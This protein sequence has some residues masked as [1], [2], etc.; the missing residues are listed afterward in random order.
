MDVAVPSSSAA[1]KQVRVHLLIPMRLSFK[2]SREKSPLER[3]AEL[4]L[5]ID[6]PE[7]RRE[8][9]M[10]RDEVLELEEGV[11]VRLDQDRLRS[12]IKANYLHE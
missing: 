4:C 3:K 7:Y 10:R 2:S 8:G 9:V 5:G 11:S 12:G 1:L 6:Y